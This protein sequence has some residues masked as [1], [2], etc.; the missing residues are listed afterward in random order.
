MDEGDKY[1]NHGEYGRSGGSSAGAASESGRHG[2]VRSVRS[3]VTATG[4]GSVAGS[5]T[6]N[7][8]AMRS[9][10]SESRTGP[11]RRISFG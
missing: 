2:S 7:S 1:S 8:A 11:R 3:A 9:V 10:F 4:G 6:N 5:G